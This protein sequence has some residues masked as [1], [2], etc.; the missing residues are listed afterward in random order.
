VFA[1]ANPD[2]QGRI[3]GNESWGYPGQIADL[4]RMPSLLQDALPWLRL[5]RHRVYAVGGSMGGQE[6]LLL[7]ARYPRLLA[8]VV[9]FDAPTNLALRYRALRRLSRG[10][11]LEWLMRREVGGT[12]GAV[13][14]RYAAR[15]PILYVR[16]IVLA[17][18][19]VELWWSRRDRTVID[20]ST[21]SGRLYRLIK[22]LDRRAPVREVVG[23]WP[24]MAEMNWRRGLPLALH[25]LGLLPT[26]SAAVRR[27]SL[28]A[29][30]MRPTTDGSADAAGQQLR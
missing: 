9:A 23:D 3:L 16:Q 2:G 20:Q 30:T 13:P 4:A 26:G 22:T 8:G 14:Q 11:Y 5:D 12:P 1:V 17:R 27:P 25:W 21:Q 6:S 18:V 29:P 19:P 24:H 7:L 10:V 28:T 15:S